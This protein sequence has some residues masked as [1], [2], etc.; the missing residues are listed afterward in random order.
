MVLKQEGHLRPVD[1]GFE[2]E[3]LILSAPLIHERTGAQHASVAGTDLQRLQLARG[4]IEGGDGV[5][6]QPMFVGQQMR[7]NGVA[8]KQ[9]QV[10]TLG[11]RRSTAAGATG[12]RTLT[13]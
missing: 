9:I 8:G 6:I 2:S 13:T 10:Q 3:P 1:G 12:V 11:Q 7:V 4:S 5:L